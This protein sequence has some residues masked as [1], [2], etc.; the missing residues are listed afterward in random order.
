M[1]LTT[2]NPNSACW[3]CLSATEKQEAK[4]YLLANLLKQ[5]GGPDYTNINALRQA[6]ACY[7]VPDATLKSFD[8][9]VAQTRLTNA[10][11]P[12]LTVAQVKTALA[13]WCNLEE[14]ELHAMETLI[15]SSLADHGA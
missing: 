12:V 11:G 10:G 5:V 2:L 15:R 13:C 9:E 3:N 1:D 8:V 4:V 6:A 14:R 7:C